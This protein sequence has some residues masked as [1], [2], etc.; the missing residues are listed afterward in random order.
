M[1]RVLGVT[2]FLILKRSPKPA[3]Y[4]VL[5]TLGQAA[6]FGIFLV[7]ARSLSPDE[8]GRLN[9]WAQ[10][11]LFPA[12]VGG[13]ALFTTMSRL[14]A[15]RRVD[16][17]SALTLGA[18]F[19]VTI[20]VSGGTGVVLFLSAGNAHENGLDVWLVFAYAAVFAATLSSVGRA[21]GLGA[22]ILAGLGNLARPI[23]TISALLLLHTPG[24][25]VQFAQFALL[26]GGMFALG[27]L[28]LWPIERDA[29]D[30]GSG[31]NMFHQTIRDL[32]ATAVAA[33]PYAGLTWFLLTLAQHRLAASEVG[34]LALA[35]QVWAALTL[36][37]A[38]FTAPALADLSRASSGDAFQRALGHWTFSS[39]VV[40]CLV[41]TGGLL[42]VWNVFPRM[43]GTYGHAV[44]PCLIMATATFVAGPNAV[45][46]HA[47]WATA[48]RAAGMILSFART[49]LILTFAWLGSK[50]GVNYLC[51]SIV[52]ALTVQA[53]V[54]MPLV[55]AR[56]RRRLIQ[57]RD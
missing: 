28:L 22:Q 7:L 18:I 53:I 19:L 24:D 8:F 50:L 31:S 15:T 25:R 1:T 49:L 45:I 27:I 5:T 17:R 40:G 46:G 3:A 52:G 37:P 2:R 16:G 9:A 13:G 34:V 39:L 43:G 42:L 4:A 56:T 36:V 47:L 20:A 38:A 51:V 32:L 12:S 26:G 55:R 21:L 6:T 11:A 57:A 30:T 48:D 23:V 29:I 14:Y 33:L 41:G 10:A 44:V 54:C 35:L